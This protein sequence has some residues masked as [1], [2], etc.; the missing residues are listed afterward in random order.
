MPE[1]FIY[2]FYR[3][4]VAAERAVRRTLWIE[5]VRSGLVTASPLR[6]ERYRADLGSSKAQI[7]SLNYA[8]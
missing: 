6:S 2:R 3:V 7:Q 1:K 5:M 4:L 8:A